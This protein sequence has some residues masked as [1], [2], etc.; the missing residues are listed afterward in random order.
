METVIGTKTPSAR[1][2]AEVVS[3]GTGTRSDSK[4]SFSPNL[5]AS[6]SK[7]ESNLSYK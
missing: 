5:S 2:R 6:R 4:R 1:R 3:S 7:L